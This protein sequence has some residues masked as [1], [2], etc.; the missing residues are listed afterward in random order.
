MKKY[1]IQPF[2]IQDYITTIFEKVGVPDNDAHIASEILVSTEMRGVSSHGI[3]RV[4]KYIN[5]LLQGG[6]HPKA[7]TTLLQEDPNFTLFDANGGLGLIASQKA[8]QYTIDK[9][10]TSSVAVAFVKNSRHFGA[11]GYY[12][13]MC[14]RQNKIGLS[15]SNG[16]II[17]AVTGSS[18]SSIGN[19]PFSFAAPAG[20]YGDMVLDMAMSKVSDGKVQIAELNQEQLDPG[21]ILDQ[22]GHPSVI[23]SDYL[24][25]GTLLPFGEHKGYGLAVMVEILAGILSGSSLLKNARAWNVDPKSRE[26]VGH[27]FL[28]LDFD[29]FMSLDLYTARVEAMIEELVGSPKKVGVKR[30]YFPGEIENLKEKEAKKSGIIVNHAC[31]LSLERAATKVGITK[32]I[33][34]L[35]TV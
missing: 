14:A 32:N 26:G 3:M 12:S 9:A 27:F 28:A 6:I 30:I 25:G 2:Q 21:A 5:C 35:F 10:N 15:M 31:A 33:F 7:S 22:E 23:P 1:T 17:M 24:N 34:D 16:D 19:N 11:A 4:E 8:M 29:K 20:K 18:T 13:L